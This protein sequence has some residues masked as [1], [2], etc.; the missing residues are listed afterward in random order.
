MTASELVA[1][2][3]SPRGEVALL[4]RG[5]TLELRVNGVFV[6]DTAETSTER[7]LADAALAQAPQAS[8]V[9]VGGLGLGYT[10]AE[11]LTDPR[12]EHV[13]VAELEPAVVDWMAQGY[14][15]HGP[16]LLADDRVEVA[17]ADLAD[18]V[19][20]IPSHTVDVALL[21]VDNGPGYLV[22]ERNAA[23]YREGFLGQV[24]RVLR[25]GGV[26]VVWAANRAIELRHALTSVFGQAQETPLPVLLQGREERYWLYSAPLPEVP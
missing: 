17:V 9:L 13:Q 12:V 10:T 1:A 6:M 11:V 22:Y 18:V 20:H 14:V 21:D 24:R 15:P 19:E 3:D 8:S 23:L 16:Q 5:R 2:R 26:V 25:P 7:A 4:R